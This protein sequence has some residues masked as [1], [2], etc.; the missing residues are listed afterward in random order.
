MRI[1]AHKTLK[2]FWRKNPEAEQ[3]LKS[4]YAEAKR[5][6]WRTTVDIKRQH[7]TAS[8]IDSEKVVFNIGGNKFRLVVY[9]WFR[10]RTL[11]IKFVGTH[12]AY[13][14]IDVTDLR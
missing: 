14:K 7:A 2:D 8:I 9:A 12:E 5:A 3:P 6:T 11:W 1:V 4:W 13:D 10:G